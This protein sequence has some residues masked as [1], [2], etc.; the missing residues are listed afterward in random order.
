MIWRLGPFW[1]EPL[2]AGRPFKAIAKIP[3]SGFKL[4]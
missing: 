4:R 2:L 3:Q 1:L